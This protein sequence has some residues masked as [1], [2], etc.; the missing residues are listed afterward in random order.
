MVLD[1]YR[2][3]VKGSV[4]EIWTIMPEMMAPSN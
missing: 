2:A 1:E 4:E 3:V